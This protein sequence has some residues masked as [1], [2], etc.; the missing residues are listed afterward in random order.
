MRSLFLLL[1]AATLTSSHAAAELTYFQDFESM[2]PGEGPAAN[3]LSADGWLVGGNVF[4]PTGTSFIYNYFA[5]P[6]PNGG[7]AFSG[8]VAGEGGAAQG[9]N[10]L[11]IYND[12][13]N[14]DHG[15]GSNNRIEANVF[16]DVGILAGSDAGQ[17]YAL[18]FDGKSGNLAAPTTAT[19]FIKVVKTSDMSFATLGNETF[20]TTSLGTDWTSGQATIQI[21]PTWVGE[22]LQIG[23]T[24]TASNFADSGNFYDNVSVSITAVPEPGSLAGLAFGSVML[25]V[26][27]RRRR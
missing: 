4:D 11:S 21:D 19:A 9:A 8:V 10:Q 23:F 7:A 15:N 17:E 22:T 18:S 26:R 5:F 2:T 12:Y 24:N 16:R 27:R 14:L 25:I 20:D 1:L 13:N 6:S 3:S